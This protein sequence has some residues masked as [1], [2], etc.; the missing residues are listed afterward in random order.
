MQLQMRRTASGRV[1]CEACKTFDRR[2][3]TL[4]DTRSLQCGI[5]VWV[6]EGEEGWDVSLSL[7]LAL[8]LALDEK[9]LRV[10]AG[11]GCGL[12]ALQS[13]AAR[14]NSDDDEGIVIEARS[15]C[16]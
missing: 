4:Q 3:E 5:F 13:F 16:L 7:R 11:R 1:S 14:E 10:G 8:A 15:L 9:H 2:E 6:E 12:A